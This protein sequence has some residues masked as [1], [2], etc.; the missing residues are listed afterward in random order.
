MV[1]SGRLQLLE[2]SQNNNYDLNDMDY[3]TNTVLPSL[4]TD[5]FVEEVANLKLKHLPGGKL[6]TEQLTK[7]VDKDRYSAVS[8]GLWY[9]KILKIK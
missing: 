3:F 4:N 6:T 2:K 7:R 1:D 8:Y 5:F 9:I